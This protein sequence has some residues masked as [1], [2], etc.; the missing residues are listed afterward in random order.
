MNLPHWPWNVYAEELF[1]AGH[2]HPLCPP[3]SRGDQRELFI[4]DVGWLRQGEFRPLF[5][6]MKPP[7]DPINAMTGVPPDF[8][9]LNHCNLY[10]RE[11]ATINHPVVHSRGIHLPESCGEDTGSV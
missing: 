5:N 2:G 9:P 1:P 4:G 10:L 11:G 7:D 3:D 6:S 8:E